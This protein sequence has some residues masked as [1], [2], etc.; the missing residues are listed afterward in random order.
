MISLQREK[1]QN[2]LRGHSV[3]HTHWTIWLKDLAYRT[4][5]ALSLTDSVWPE[6]HTVEPLLL[7]FHIN[8]DVQVIKEE[9]EFQTL[10]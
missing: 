2:A 4:R 6:K 9:T 10:W 3:R 5:Y 1:N 7:T 8:L